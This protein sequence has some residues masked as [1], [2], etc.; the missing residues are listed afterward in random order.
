M[1]RGKD[2]LRFVVVTYGLGKLLQIQAARH[3][4]FREQLKCHDLTA[5][6]RL[7]DGSL[8]RYFV[9]SGGRIVSKRGFRPSPQVVMSFRDAAVATRV[10]RPKRDRLEF[11][12]AAK[13]YQLELKGDGRL[14]GHFTDALTGV[15][16]AGSSYGVKL[17]GGVVRYTNN[18]NGGPVFVYVKNGKII[19]ITP[20]TLDKGDAAPW[21]IKARGRTFTPPRKTTVSPHALAWKSLIYSPYRV[22]HPLKR[23]DFD[24]KGERNPQTRGVSGYER[25]SW[26][27]ALDLVASEIKRV[28]RDHGP[29]AIMSGSGSH[30]T[31]GVIGYWLSARFRFLHAVGWTPVVSN[32]DR[33]GGLLVERS[34]SD[35]RDIWC[36][37]GYRPPGLA[38]GVGPVP[39]AHRSVLQSHGRMV[40]RHVVGSAARHRQRP[41]A[42]HRSLVDE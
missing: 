2:R 4:A 12:N 9:L 32:P 14:V 19:R 36:A 27:E 31:W 37:G 35:Q 30:H 42:G 15:F 6:L 7:L 38:E 8:G 10:L 26:H 41:G 5:Q 11:L 29:G 20:I 1:T 40:G 18:T 22:L 34:R 16:S 13:N 3:R 21:T 24:P 39:G 17:P 28:K 33:D 25:I 23:V